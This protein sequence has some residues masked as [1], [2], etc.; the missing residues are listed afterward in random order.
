MRQWPQGLWVVTPEGK[1]LGFHYHKPKPGEPYA[2]GQTRWVRETV[3]MTRD[4][5]TAAGPLAPRDL[6]TTPNPFPDRG[7]G[8]NSD[9]GARLAVGVIRV[10]N[11][12][13]D[14]PPVV[15]SVFLTRERWDG[16][17]PRAGEVKAG[18]EWAVPEDAAARF[19]PA[20][21]PMTDSIFSPKPDD[22][23]AAK[24][25]ARVAR[26]GD[27]Y[28]VIRYE[29]SWETFHNR[30][31]DP[32]YPIRTAA[33]GEGVGVYD[34]RT[35]KLTAAAWLIPGTFRNSPPGDKPQR[36]VAVVEWVA[37]E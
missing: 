31:G 33:T 28:A 8:T 30:D 35:G 7:K 2:E 16:F 6:K 29:G 15:D 9:G 19:A 1:V 21:S 11:G 12:R 3:Q 5:I 18:Q 24:V 25:T 20:F 14:G 32:K 4:A 26:V 13:Q 37:G 23:T 10:I 27:G 34:T 17:R 22:V 36:T